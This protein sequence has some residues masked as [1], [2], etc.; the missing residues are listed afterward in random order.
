MK[1]SKEGNRSIMMNVM[2]GLNRG[3][4]GPLMDVM[5]EELTSTV[6]MLSTRY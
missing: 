5:K 4:S 6:P 2:M 3:S 1:V